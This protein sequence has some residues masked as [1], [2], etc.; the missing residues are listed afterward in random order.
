MWL[1]KPDDIALVEERFRVLTRCETLD[2]S[3][4]RAAPWIGFRRRMV[5]YLGDD[6]T[7]TETEM[8]HSVDTHRMGPEVRL[9]VIGAYEDARVLEV[10][11]FLE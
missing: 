6:E 10:D 11:L 2:P 5:R 7:M 1:I 3:V 4:L 9:L 8:L